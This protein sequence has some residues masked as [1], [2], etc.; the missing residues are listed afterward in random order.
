MMVFIPSKQP[1]ITK[2]NS[3][4]ITML[5]TDGEEE[6]IP[7]LK[8]ALYFTRQKPSSNVDLDRLRKKGQ[9]DFQCINKIVPLKELIAKYQSERI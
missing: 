8:V 5:I 3:D 1:L 4:D 7:E 2:M 6:E 9:Y